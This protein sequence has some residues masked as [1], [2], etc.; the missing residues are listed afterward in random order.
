VGG[1]AKIKRKGDDAKGATSPES[2]SDEI[3][4]RR[5]RHPTGSISDYID[6]RPR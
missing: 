2:T 6:I 4:I 1:T 3:D 5:D